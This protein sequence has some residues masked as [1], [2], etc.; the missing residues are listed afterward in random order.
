MTCF[1]N[2]H[3]KTID[4]WCDCKGMRC[5][6]MK[7]TLALMKGWSCPYVKWH[8]L[9]LR[10]SGRMSFLAPPSLIWLTAS[11]L[12][13]SHKLS[14]VLFL[15]VSTVLIC[16]FHSFKILP[17]FF[18]TFSLHC[19]VLV[20][21]ALHF[22]FL[23]FILIVLIVFFKLIPVLVEL[24]VLQIVMLKRYGI[25]A[26]DICVINIYIDK[27]VTYV[28]TYVRTYIFIIFI[29][30]APITSMLLMRI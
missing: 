15:D 25:L 9:V 30:S 10:S 18:L 22:I 23:T 1:F 28:R 27:Y 21:I 26:V 5:F 7:C 3:V 29:S 17:T 19:C 12:G 20:V 4:I 2:C 6:L 8:F 24:T 14:N 13:E 16:V 11:L